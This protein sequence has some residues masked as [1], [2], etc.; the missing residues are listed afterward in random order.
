LDDLT[1]DSWYW[2][3]GKLSSWLHP[4]C[5][6]SVRGWNGRKGFKWR[7]NSLLMLNQLKR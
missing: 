3:L 5:R 4:K 2:F 1:L 6:I 7:R